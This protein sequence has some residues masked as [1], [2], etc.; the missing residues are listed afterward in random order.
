MLKLGVT[1]LSL[2]SCT[3]LERFSLLCGHIRYSVLNSLGGQGGGAE[4][5]SAIQVA[6]PEPP[7]GVE[8]ARAYA[9][10]QQKCLQVAPP[11]CFLEHL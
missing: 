1:V 3:S 6:G 8:G 9:R 10:V 11:C 2:S 5:S 4:G 7:N